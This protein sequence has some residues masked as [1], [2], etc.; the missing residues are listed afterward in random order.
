[1]SHTVSTI[2]AGYDVP[3]SFPWNLILASLPVV[4]AVSLLAAW[5]PARRAMQ[6]QVIEAIGYE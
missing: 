2:L 6:V 3:Y 4:T 5:L 1:M